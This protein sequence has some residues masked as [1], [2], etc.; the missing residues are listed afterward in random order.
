MRHCLI[1]RPISNSITRLPDYSITKFQRSASYAISRDENIADFACV[2]DVGERVGV[3]RDEVSPLARFERAEFRIDL[4]AARR[5]AR[6]RG[7][8]LTRRQARFRHQLEFLQL[9]E[10]LEAAD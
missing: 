2:G 6:C 1:Q 5:V 9:E 8:H 4:H 3:E 7:E 10:S